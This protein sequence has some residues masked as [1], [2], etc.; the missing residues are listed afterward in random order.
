MEEDKSYESVKTVPFDPTRQVFDEW[1]YG[2]FHFLIGA[3]NTR[4]FYLLKTPAGELVNLPTPADPDVPTAEETRAIEKHH[5][6]QLELYSVLMMCLPKH[7]QHIASVGQP[8]MHPHGREACRKLVEYFH[9]NDPGYLPELSYAVQNLSL[10]E[11]DNQA[12]IFIYQ[13]DHKCSMLASHA[14]YAVPVQAKITTL[15]RALKADSRFDHIIQEHTVNPYAGTAGYEKLKQ[16]TVAFAR[17]FKASESSTDPAAQP[18]SRE[19]SLNLR[20]GRKPQQRRRE[21]LRD[22][23][24]VDL[25]FNCGKPG[26][27][28]RDCKEAKQE[29]A[30]QLQAI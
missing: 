15:I 5:R 21:K 13:L 29:R 8:P 9:D 16:T 20:T 14:E 27:Y 7:L 10:K 11:F 22:K 30:N 4:V 26:H 28:A 17:R 12:E 6:D 23:D 2:D 1:F 25:C 18:R 3:K 24:G 19:Q